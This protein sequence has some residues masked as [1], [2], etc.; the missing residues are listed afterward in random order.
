M[1]KEFDIGK[2]FSAGWELFK[3]NMST[4][5]LGSLIVGV[6]S[7]LTFYILTGPLVVGFLW[8]AD[9]LD[10]QDPIKPTA[11][12]VFKGMSKF[13]DAFV[14]CLLFFIVALVAS[15]IPVIGQIAAY[16]VS[17][18]LMFTLMY[19][20]YEEM[21]AIDAFKKVINGVTSGKMLMPIVMGIIANLIGSAGILLCCVGG[22]FTMPLALTLYLCAYKQLP[23]GDNI[24][25]A[26]I[27]EEKPTPP[28]IP[29]DP[30]IGSADDALPT[31][32]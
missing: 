8:I 6:L 2:C 16:V 29:D 25:D 10:K 24:T 17:P 13:G 1:K 30:D 23:N 27:I 4:L 18:M 9:R 11:G 3:N 14:A 26:E 5:I 7:A 20:A 19:V 22:I 31:A 28:F 15:I 32:E 12:D 21:S